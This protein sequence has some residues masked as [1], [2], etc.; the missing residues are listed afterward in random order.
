M[1]AL[2][3]QAK[4]GESMIRSTTA[5]EEFAGV[6]WTDNIRPVS[7]V[8]QRR[9]L[10]QFHEEQRDRPEKLKPSRRDVEQATDVPAITYS[11]E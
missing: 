1:R 3:T 10:D 11:E 6:R 9:V 4:I 2:A 7:G 8:T 5:Q